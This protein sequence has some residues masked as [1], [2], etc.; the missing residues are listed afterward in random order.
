MLDRAVDQDQIIRRAVLV[1]FDERTLDHSDAGPGQRGHCALRK[2]LILF[3]RDDVADQPG[4]HRGG[5]AGGRTDH[6]SPLA[7]LRRSFSEQLAKR[8]R[9]IKLASAAER[10]QGIGISDRRQLGR[11]EA[12]ARHRAHRREHARIIDAGSPQLARDHRSA[13]LFEI[14]L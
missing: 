2:R 1:T 12:L 6:H 11:N 13:H 3:D 10:D 5:I 9:R 4:E 7:R 8:H 14:M